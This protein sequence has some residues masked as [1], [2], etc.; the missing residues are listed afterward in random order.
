MALPTSLGTFALGT[1]GFASSAIHDLPVVTLV[2]PIG[3]VTTGPT[4]TVSW[5]YSQAQGDAQ[6]S[7]RV[8]FTNDSGSVVY[9]DAGWIGGAATSVAYDFTASGIPANSTDLAVTVSVRSVLGAPYEGTTGIQQFDSAL[10]GPSVTIT[11]PLN[12]S[13]VNST[14]TT[15]TWTYSDT[16]AHAQIAYRVR[17]SYTASMVLLYDSGWTSSAGTSFLL[18][19]PLSDGSQYTTRV[20][21]RNTNLV[22]AFASTAWQTDIGSS[23]GF[24]AL[25]SVGTVYEIGI[26]G[27]GYM[28]ADDPTNQQTAYQRVTTNLDPTRFATSSTPFSES[29]QHYLIAGSGDFKSG[30]GQKWRDRDASTVDAYFDSQDV[31]PFVAGQL[32]LLNST[33]QEISSAYANLRLAVAS[34]NLY[35][36]TGDKQLTFRTTPGGS[37][38]S[39]NVA[40]ATVISDLATDGS[41]WYAA[42][43][44]AGIF[45]GTTSDPGAAWSAITATTADWAGGR[46]CAAL[47]ASGTTANRF[48][49][50]N[51]A[52]A[53]EVASGRLTLP[54]GWTITG[55]TGGSGH[56]WFGS[57]AGDTGIVY[58]WDLTAA[59]PFAVFEMPKGEIPMAVKYYLGDVIILAKQIVSNTLS[60]M[61][62]Y[63]CVA[64]A[65][66]TLTPTLVTTVGEPIPTQDFGAAPAISAEGRFVLFSWPFLASATSSGVGAIDLST[67]GYA[68]WY[69]STSAGGQ[70]ASI[71]VWQGRTVFVIRGSGVWLR[72]DMS[73]VASGWLETSLADGNSSLGKIVDQVTV[74]TQPLGASQ[75]I[76]ISTTIDGGNSYVAQPSA[77]LSGAGAKTKTTDLDLRSY[78]AGL[79]VTLNGPT[80]STPTLHVVQIRYHPQ[81]LADTTVQ[82]TINC[83]DWLKGLNG[84]DLEENGDGAGAR[85]ARTIEGL[86]QT[87]VLF[88][89]R[90]WHLIGLSENYE[91]IQV[92][93]EGVAVNDRNMPGNQLGQRAT[94]QLRK[95]AK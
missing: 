27:L 62:V 3:T 95:R 78:N 57:Y 88:Q 24:T 9:F 8:V 32:T 55:F 23:V 81:G 28:L 56:V 49:T 16:G 22:E 43:G 69:R 11:A 86:M 45:R 54:V 94:I 30:S 82:C 40:A 89:D 48:T 70:V 83:G 35:V 93:V 66:G 26:N 2:G 10:G 7:Y 31:N 61:T 73:Y 12:G 33:A 58:A 38:T 1:G 44:A 14:S 5:N 18:P 36:Q 50:L 29:I 72:S 13:V 84:A 67:G 63:R 4:V 76:D 87:V 85:R 92:L 41:Q 25:P 15:V 51:D 42:A 79:K 65:N 20:D 53:E 77:S 37:S 34:G 75:S 21:V 52:G 74:M 71:D 60:R 46:L 90:D 91:V 39:F 19:Y 17:L 64:A 6:G 80:S 47:V 68:K 59:A